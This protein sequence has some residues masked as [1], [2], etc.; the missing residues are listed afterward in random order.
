MVLELPLVEEF[1]DLYLYYFVLHFGVPDLDFVG[2]E[3]VDT[4]VV[5]VEQVLVDAVQG[6][7]DVE[8]AFVDTVVL[9]VVADTV[10]DVGLGIVVDVVAGIVDF[11]YHLDVLHIE[12]VDRDTAGC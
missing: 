5:V 10:V 9:D 3:F 12:V 2:S 11:V 4:E 8:Q 6:F 7:V 1:V